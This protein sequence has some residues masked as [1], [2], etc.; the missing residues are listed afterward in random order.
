MRRVVRFR[1][2]GCYPLSGAIESRAT[3]VRRD[4]RRDG[5]GGGLG[6]PGP[7]DRHRPARPPWRRR[8]GRAT[9]ERSRSCG[10][11]RAAAWT[12]ASPRSSDG[13]CTSRARCS[14]TSCARS[15]PT[16]ASSARRARGSTSRC[17]STGCR[18]SASRASPSTW[19]TASSPRRA[20]RFIVADTPGH[21]QYTRNMATGASTADLAVILDRRA[22]GR[23]AADAPPHPH[24]GDDGHPARAAGR[25]QDGPG[26]TTEQQV[27]DAIV[28]EYAPFAAAVRHHQRAARSRCRRSRATT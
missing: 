4:H 23:A 28:D 17:W 15:R 25:Q 13:C 7:P 8:S 21:E 14:R 27:F 3:T 6:A 20:R 2:L 5:R 22:Q 24:R 19:P 9:S 1:T 18:P 16:R 12:T 26:R 11:S 10:S